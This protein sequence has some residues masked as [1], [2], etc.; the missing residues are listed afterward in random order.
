MTAAV[1][2]GVIAGIIL[3]LFLGYYLWNTARTQYGY[4]IFNL[5]VIVRGLLSF[6]CL[7]GVYV[8]L[9][10]NDQASVWVCMA[11]GTLLWVWT[12][13]S[14]L[15]NTNFFI[16]LFSIVYQFFAVLFVKKVIEKI[17]G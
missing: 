17:F 15:R 13:I 3:F 16:A 1:I 7:F 5:G 9:Q 6:G 11:V 12:F 8:F 10:N 14:T 4:N 2:I